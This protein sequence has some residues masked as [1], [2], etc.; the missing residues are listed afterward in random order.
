MF[1][2]KK[3]MNETMSFCVYF[4]IDNDNLPDI[5]VNSLPNEPNLYRSPNAAS[6]R[7]QRQEVSNLAKE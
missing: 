7:Q 3:F 2:R 5:I 1:H 4:T 6:V